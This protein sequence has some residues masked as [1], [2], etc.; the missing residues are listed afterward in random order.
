MRK[1]ISCKVVRS[2]P[3]GKQSASLS[4]FD[5]KIESTNR[6]IRN[7]SVF[8]AYFHTDQPDVFKTSVIDNPP[9]QFIDFYV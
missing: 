1:I 4:G 2:I 6:K 9:A 8:C 3:L 7:P 5:N